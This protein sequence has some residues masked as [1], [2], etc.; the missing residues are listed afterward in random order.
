MI[1]HAH[2]VTH[3]TNPILRWVGRNQGCSTSK[4]STRGSHW[5][6]S[7]LCDYFL[8]ELITYIGSLFIQVACPTFQPPCLRHHPLVLKKLTILYS[9]QK[10]L[11]V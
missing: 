9:F 5:F 3:L 2:N 6:I 8:C 11:C 10:L 1:I 4:N 7:Y